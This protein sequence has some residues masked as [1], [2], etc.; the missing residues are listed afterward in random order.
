MKEKSMNYRYVMP[1]LLLSVA[2]LSISA[3]EGE[4]KKAANQNSFICTIPLKAL[5][6]HSLENARSMDGS[7]AGI[8][9]ALSKHKVKQ[10]EVD[11]TVKFNVNINDLVKQILETRKS[12][13]DTSGLRVTIN[14]V[15][16]LDE[17]SV[18]SSIE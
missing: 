12:V 3:G 18:S 8:A 2:T 1:V 15:V 6:L 11:V 17:L 9:K 13:G 4:I 14:A 10:D 5:L 7:R 16:S